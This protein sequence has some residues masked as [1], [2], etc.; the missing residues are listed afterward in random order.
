MGSCWYTPP[1]KP[2]KVIMNCNSISNPLQ[3]NTSHLILQALFQLY[4]DPNPSNKAAADRWLQSLQ[5]SPQAWNLS[6]LLLQ[7]QVRDWATRFQLSPKWNESSQ[8]RLAKPGE[9]YRTIT[10]CDMQQ[11]LH[12]G[13]NPVRSGDG[14]EWPIELITTPNSKLNPS[15]YVAYCWIPD[16]KNQEC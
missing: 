5:M 12:R 6:W 16:L 10:Y 11:T 3:F 8:A 13:P 1:V 14:K 2:W 4:Q 7:H 9:K 15:A